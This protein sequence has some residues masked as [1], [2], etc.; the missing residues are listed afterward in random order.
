MSADWSRGKNTRSE[1]WKALQEKEEHAKRLARHMSNMEADVIER[2]DIT[3]SIL[4]EKFRANAKSAGLKASGDIFR[5]EEP[6]R[7]MRTNTIETQGSESSQQHLEESD[8]GTSEGSE[9]QESGDDYNHGVKRPRKSF[10]ASQASKQRKRNY[11]PENDKDSQLSEVDYYDNYPS[12]ASDQSTTDIDQGNLSVMGIREVIADEEHDGEGDDEANVQDEVGPMDEVIQELCEAEKNAEPGFYPLIRALYH[13]ARD[14]EFKEPY[15]KPTLSRQQSFLWDYVHSR[16]RS[17]GNMVPSEQKDIFVAVSGIVDLELHTSFPQ[18][19][20]LVKRCRAG[21][22][23]AFPSVRQH[24]KS[25]HA[26]VDVQDDVEEVRLDDL[27]R[28]LRENVAQFEEGSTE[29]MIT[30]ILRI[31]VK[32]CVP[33]KF[34]RTKRTESYTLFVWYAV[35]E[36][37]FSG[38]AVEVEVGETILREAQKDQ[39]AIRTVVGAAAA[40]GRA[41]AAGRKL[42]FRLIASIKT[43]QCYEPFTLSNDE[44]KGLGSSTL[45]AAIQRKKN[46]RLNKSIV[47]NGKVPMTTGNVYQD[48]VGLEGTWNIMC[49]FEDVVLCCE[50]EEPPLR[51]PSNEFELGVFLLEDGMERLLAYREH[52]LSL[53]KK[54]QGLVANPRRSSVSR[55]AQAPTNSLAKNAAVRRSAGCDNDALQELEMPTTKPVKNGTTSTVPCTP[56]RALHPPHLPSFYTPTKPKQ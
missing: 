26:F 51:L 54:V 13:A 55:R 40:V 28:Q 56:P 27:K 53:A 17:F 7:S 48:V 23:F 43:G 42:D 12:D 35:W 47:M 5:P 30:E 49:P 39:A 18:R 3:S 33:D 52:I 34:G 24:M 45:T 21:V 22:S 6:V 2:S 11:P 50:S 25:Y 9:V 32:Q 38:T 44:H 4:T 16:L 37:L 20:E 41:G 46:M 10:P 14:Q 8:S 19:D 31:L 29:A 36:V 1:Y 15:P